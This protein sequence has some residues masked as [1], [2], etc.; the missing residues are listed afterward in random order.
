MQ[1]MRLKVSFFF[2]VAYCSASLQVTVDQTHFSLMVQKI[3]L[4]ASRRI[5]LKIAQKG[6]STFLIKGRYT[7]IA[8]T[9]AHGLGAF[10]DFL[11]SKQTKGQLRAVEQLEGE[12]A[13]LTDLIQE[14]RE[15]EEKAT[16]FLTSN[17]RLR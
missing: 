1:N 5:N 15:A 3:G 6:G 4:N 11:K 7:S 9:A 2:L 10:K 14:L 13:N 16:H 17:G 12:L 8:F